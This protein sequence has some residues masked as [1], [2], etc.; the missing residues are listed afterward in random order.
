MILIF[1]YNRP[2]MLE[3]L[4]DELNYKFPTERIIVIDDGSTYLVPFLHKCEYHRLVH[5]GKEF[6]WVNWEYAFTICEQSD[7]DFFMF[8][9]DDF[10]NI[11]SVR[12]NDIYNI[13]DGLYAYNLLNDSRPPC[14]TPIKHIEERVAGVPSIRSSF[15]DC[16]YFT[17]RATLEAI[18]F[19][20]DYIHPDR[21]T[22]EDISSGVGQ[23]QSRKFY[24]LGIPMYIPKKSLCYHGEHDSV[25]H[26][27][28]RKIQPLISKYG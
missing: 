1:S 3:Q 23:T 8:L 21:F 16:G 10:S 19:E 9:P 7:D 12:I 20:Q 25:M 22:R 11:D 28:L 17:N 5:K 14:W 13:K 18:N 2:N 24:K 4:L 15:V 26:Y 27:E 6:F